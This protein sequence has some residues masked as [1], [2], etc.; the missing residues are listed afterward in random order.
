[1]IQQSKAGFL[2]KSTRQ[3]KEDHPEL[4]AYEEFGELL[5]AIKGVLDQKR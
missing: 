3:L 4:P 1:M 5:E 2:F